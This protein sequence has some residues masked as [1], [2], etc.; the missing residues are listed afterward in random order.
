VL[1]IEN[2]YALGM[3]P[4]TTGA[5]CSI[6]NTQGCLLLAGSMA[7]APPVGGEIKTGLLFNKGTLHPRSNTEVPQTAF[8]NNT[9][10]ND[11][12][13]PVQEIQYQKHGP[14]PAG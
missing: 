7:G 11:P 13:V 12:Y 8:F 6:F 1:S 14:I 3:K 4:V 5:K 9:S 2:F 10:L